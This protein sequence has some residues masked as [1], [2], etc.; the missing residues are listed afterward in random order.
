MTTY[1]EYLAYEH[2]SELTTRNPVPS[3]HGGFIAE[4]RDT[5]L[6]VK[7]LSIFFFASA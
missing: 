7:R 3:P 1:E 2:D 6:S 5:L 4:G